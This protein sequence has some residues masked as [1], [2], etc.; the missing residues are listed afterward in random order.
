MIKKSRDFT[1]LLFCFTVD[2][3]V[4]GLAFARLYV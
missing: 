2:L 1:S 3:L 4:I